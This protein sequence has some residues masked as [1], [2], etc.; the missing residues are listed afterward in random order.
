MIHSSESAD[1]LENISPTEIPQQFVYLFTDQTAKPVGKNFD[2]LYINPIKERCEG[3][4]SSHG[5][6]LAVLST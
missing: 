5:T 1:K 4:E 6:E 3:D 2:E